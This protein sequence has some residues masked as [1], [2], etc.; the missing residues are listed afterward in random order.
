MQAP[1]E[2]GLWQ[3]ESEGG[4]RGAATEEWV[5]DFCELS[6]EWTR[7][8]S[9]GHEGGIIERQWRRLGIRCQLA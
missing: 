5:S 8:P 2:L 4:R 9:S 3:T 7:G 6:W 1:T